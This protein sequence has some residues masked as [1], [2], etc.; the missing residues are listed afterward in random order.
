MKREPSDFE[1]IER[2]EH[3]TR[4]NQLPVAATSSGG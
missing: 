1:L 2:A 3:V 4:A